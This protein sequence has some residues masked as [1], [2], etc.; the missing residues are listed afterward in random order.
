MAT[1]SIRLASVEEVLSDPGYFPVH[2]DLAGDRL[3]FVETS[4]SRL[5]SLPFIDGRFRMTSGAAVEMALT[6]ALAAR[7]T[8]PPGPDRFIFHVA[9]CGSTRLATLLDVP[10]RSFGQREPRL[11]NTIADACGSQSTSLAPSALQLARSL[12][13]RPWRPGERTFCKPSNWA[14]NLIPALTAHP[15][16]IRPLFLAIDSRDHL[17]AMF[18]GGR[19]RIAYVFDATRHLLGA[20]PCHQALWDE[21]I[22]RRATAL[23]VAARIALVSL[24]LQLGLFGDA[25]RRGGWTA[26]NLLSLRQIEED[27]V[28]ACMVAARALGLNITSGDM[29]STIEERAAVYAKAP[30]RPYSREAR[31]RLN[32]QIESEYGSVFDRALEWA[33]GAGLNLDAASILPAKN[34]GAIGIPRLA[35]G[36]NR[37]ASLS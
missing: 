8:K 19:E 23:D 7:W 29:I 10:G 37:W 36:S 16:H 26:A 14:N 6:D 24:H 22:R 1:R 25:M 12:L 2:I 13:R 34:A 30:D 15:Q 5:A 32:A 17:L 3:L 4:R 27:P 18:R 9:F 31:R 33:A 11:L 20:S 21:A 28:H 35:S